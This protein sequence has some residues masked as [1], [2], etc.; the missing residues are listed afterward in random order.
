MAFKFEIIQIPHDDESVRAYLEQYKAF[1]LYSLKTAPGAFGS[2][3][4]R[5]IA[6]TDDIWYDRL[7]N[8]IA[9]TFFAM[10]SDRVVCMLTAMGPLACT[11]EEFT[12][13][14]DPWTFLNKDPAAT[15]QSHFRVNGMFTLPEARGQGVAKALMERF[16]KY[17]AVE[18]AKVGKEFVSSIVVDADNPPAR[19]LYEKCGFVALSEEPFGPGGS[20]IAVL[21][22]YDPNSSEK[23]TS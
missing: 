12:P 20:R 2:T 7:A 11:P 18:A 19:N 13:S 6:F 23:T 22:K 16:F 3:Y 5:E 9:N 10:Q 8:P 1:R 4:E 15:V 14:T 21:M 17:G